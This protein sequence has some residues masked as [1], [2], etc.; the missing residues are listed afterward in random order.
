MKI[1]RTRYTLTAALSCCTQLFYLYQKHCQLSVRYASQKNKRNCYTKTK[2]RSMSL[3]LWINFWNFHF[4]FLKRWR[5]T[6]QADS[7][8]KINFRNNYSIACNKSFWNCWQIVHVYLII[9]YK[10]ANIVTGYI[11]PKMLLV[12]I[13]I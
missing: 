10:I 5:S 8:L 6:E 9:I 1:F 4:H 7:L 12:D 2:K 11:S 3:H 13:S